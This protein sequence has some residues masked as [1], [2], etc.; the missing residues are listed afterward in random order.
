LVALVNELAPAA[1]PGAAALAPGALTPA[2]FA[3]VVARMSAAPNGATAA[4]QVTLVRHFLI[5]PALTPQQIHDLVSTLVN[6]A[7]GTLTPQEL[8]T[9]VNRL[10]AGATGIGPALIRSMVNKFCVATVASR[11]APADLLYVV[12]SVHPHGADSGTR[13]RSTI[14]PLVNGAH[15]INPQQV[16]AVIR[17]F[18]AAAA[19]GANGLNGTQI[20][21]L[22]DL[23]NPPAGG[24]PPLNGTEMHDIFDHLMA[25]AEDPPINPTQTSEVVTRLRA[26]LVP[27]AVH[28]VTGSLITVPGYGARKIRPAFILD[29]V[30]RNHTD[31]RPFAQL[32]QGCIA[33]SSVGDAAVMLR[34]LDAC[35]YP[36]DN[37]C[38][39]LARLPSVLGT[40]RERAEKWWRFIVASPGAAE[41]DLARNIVRHLERFFSEGRYPFGT[42]Q[43]FA[44]TDFA[45]GPEEFNRVIGDRRFHFSEG[46]L[47]YFCNAHTY[48]H[49]D[50]EDRLRRRIP[51]CEMFSPP[52]RKADVKAALV[53]VL[54]TPG[55]LG[56]AARAPLVRTRDR[57]GYV[58]QTLGGNREVG[59]KKLRHGGNEV[60]SVSH[61]SPVD[62]A[63]I[64]RDAMTVIHLLFS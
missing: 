3:H 11:I 41:G 9:F 17:K 52:F 4:Q 6:N 50:F 53:A 8:C 12:D 10:R 64:S 63:R 38:T 16:L 42:E 49:F 61:F 1:G 45:D 24:P 7:A 31:G 35:G 21:A 20:G 14:A 59:V 2:Q 46:S 34:A 29:M 26:H 56:L 36:A 27:S 55:M 18:R 62:G 25:S 5:V 44:A 30:Q 51:A 47:N 15:S 48:R 43:P 54:E 39:L 33:A 58:M 22:I 40:A 60:V 19:G 23:L 57:E 28:S 37:V 32:L 13:V